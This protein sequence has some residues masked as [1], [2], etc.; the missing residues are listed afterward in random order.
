[1]LPFALEAFS[2]G[3]LFFYIG[4]RLKNVD[5]IKFEGRKYWLLLLMIV[6]WIGSICQNGCVDMR[7]ARYYNP[8]LYIVNGAL[9]TIIFWN[10]AHFISCHL[11]KLNNVLQHFSIC[12]ITYLC[13]HYIFVFYGNRLLCRYLSFSG[14]AIKIILFVGVVLIS[15]ILNKM[16]MK[17]VPRLI[18][19][20][21]V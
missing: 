12:S 14:T 15:W 21:N 11:K 8:I 6:I 9:G 7:S 20:K 10:I 4:I 18:G 2:T 3:I 19:K 17:Y 13:V 1:M 16:I 5:W